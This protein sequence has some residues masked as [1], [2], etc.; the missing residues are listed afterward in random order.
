MARFMR[1]RSVKSDKAMIDYSLLA[2][3]L[4]WS[5]EFPVLEDELS[6]DL[7]RH[8]IHYRTSL[9]RGR[10]D[11]RVE[12]YWNEARRLFPQWIGFDPARCTPDPELQRLD[13]E[14]AK[15]AMAEALEGV[16]LEGLDLEGLDL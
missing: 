3:G 16:D 13:K 6:D 5:D 11:K 15:K 2:D 9:I 7:I 4:H 12:A 1:R 14:F 8:L 10:P